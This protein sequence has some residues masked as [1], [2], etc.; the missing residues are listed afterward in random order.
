[1]DRF[2]WMPRTAIIEVAVLGVL[3]R[4]VKVDGSDLSVYGSACPMLRR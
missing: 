1:M 3:P 4:W 2:A